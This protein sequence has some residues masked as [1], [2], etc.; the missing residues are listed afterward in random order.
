M[1]GRLARLL[2]AAGHDA[3]LV[4]A[5]LDD[6]DVLAWARREERVLLTRDRRLA[7][8]AG[9]H[10]FLIEANRPDEQARDL[11]RSFEIDWLADPF[12]RCL[13]DNHLLRPATVREV[14]ALPLSQPERPRPIRA[15]PECA[16]LYWPGSH[17]R[18]MLGKLESLARMPVLTAEKDA[19]PYARPRGTD[20]KGEF[21]DRLRLPAARS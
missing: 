3:A 1:L 2:R 5:E 8:D 14:Q 12:T 18:R 7:E 15:C 19:D 17:V 6:G 20:L 13:L 21:G 9:F 16:R 4:P 10:A 11:A